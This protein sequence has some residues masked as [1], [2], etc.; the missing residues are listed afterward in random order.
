M[1]Y[2]LKVPRWC[3]RPPPCW[4]WK[5]EGVQ[6]QSWLLRGPAHS[7]TRLV[8]TSRQASCGFTADDPL[9]AIVPGKGMTFTATV[10]VHSHESSAHYP[11]W[12]WAGNKK[13]PVWTIVWLV[14]ITPLH[15]SCMENP[16]IWRQDSHLNLR[17]LSRNSDERER[18]RSPERDI[19]HHTRRNG[20]H[21]FL[22]EIFT[23]QRDC[24]DHR[25]NTG[26]LSLN[27]KTF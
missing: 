20:G 10:H 22:L 24:H 11:Q 14:V 7:P 4:I 25:A 27:K 6:R 15:R 26:I 16:R 1:R 8:D 12:D 3:T 5:R 17:E 2:N 23:R 19:S 18:A 13:T 21:A 9:Y